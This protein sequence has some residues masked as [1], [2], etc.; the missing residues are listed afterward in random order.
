ME[1]EEYKSVRRW[2]AKNEYKASTKS[3]YLQVIGMFCKILDMNPDQ[4]AD[5]ETME[6]LLLQQRLVE[7]VKVKR[8]TRA[9][10]MVSRLSILHSF[11]RANDVR[12]TRDIRQFKG[13]PSL[14]RVIKMHK[15]K[16]PPAF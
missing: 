6:A 13:S 11:W 3:V 15:D 4:L 12:V 16:K 8:D 9:Y 7:A 2:F 1:I 10:S 14:Q 5:V